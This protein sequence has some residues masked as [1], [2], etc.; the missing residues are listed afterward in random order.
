MFDSIK[1]WFAN[2]PAVAPVKMQAQPIH[3]NVTI[4]SPT[5]VQRNSSRLARLLAAKAKGQGTPAIDQEI[6]AR[7]KAVDLIRGA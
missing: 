5:Q 6:A 4:G 1:K 7:Q 2:A 3:L